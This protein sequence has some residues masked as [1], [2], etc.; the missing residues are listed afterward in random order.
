M[1]PLRDA[2]SSDSHCEGGSPKQSRA[3]GWDCFAPSGDPST[4]LRFAQ[5]AG[6]RSQWQ[7][8]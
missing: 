6:L 4:S 2:P 3:Q 5:D 8:L 1:P 7:Y